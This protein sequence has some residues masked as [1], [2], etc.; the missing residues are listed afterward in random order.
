MSGPQ[1]RA[2]VKCTTPEPASLSRLEQK[3]TC[4]VDMWQDRYDMAND[5]V[6]EPSEDYE[7]MYEEKYLNSNK[8]L[9]TN[10]TDIPLD[11]YDNTCT[12]I[13]KAYEYPRE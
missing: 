6:Y 8:E 2:S 7:Q 11:D 13:Q 5:E 4:L 10:Q 12:C 1:T 9:A 3:S